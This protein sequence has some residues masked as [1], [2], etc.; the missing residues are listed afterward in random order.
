MNIKLLE[1]IKICKNQEKELKEKNDFIGKLQIKID[2]QKDE[3][4]KLTEKLNV[5]II[6]LSKITIN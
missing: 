2:K 3:I 5:E 4:K 1:K 6:F